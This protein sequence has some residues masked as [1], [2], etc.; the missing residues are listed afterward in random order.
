M[1]SGGSLQL[2][3]AVV[4]AIDAFFGPR[5]SDVDAGRA[6]VRDGIVEL[7]RLGAFEADLAD[8]VAIVARVARHD[9]AS[10]F[11]AWAHR[12]VVEYLEAAAEGVAAGE[13][14]AAGEAW[15]AADPTVVG[16]WLDELRT[17]RRLGAT[18]MAA[19]TA[20]VLAG[21]PLPVSATRVDGH[22]ELRG[23]VPWASN[24]LPPFLVV[25]AVARGDGAAGAIV[26]ALPSEVANVRVDP[27]P[28]LLALNATGS[29]SLRLDGVPVTEERVLAADLGPFVGRILAPFLLVQSAF[30]LGLAERALE[31][32]ETALGPLGAPL[33]PDLDGTRRD[34]DELTR[35][36]AALARRAS[37]ESTAIPRRELLEHRLEAARVAGEAVRL[38]LAAVGGR[39]YVRGHPTERR[40]REAAF[41]PIQSPTEVLLRWLLSRDS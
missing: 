32:A 15:A 17:G 28:D 11:S 14:I 22:L 5:A 24:L 25:T 34:H 16:R 30:C 20:H 18:A 27:Y 1:A 38:E 39:A 4:R 19:G 31:E 35:Q 10:A 37:I 12:S 36:L 41:L 13:G 40:L 23:R 9:L 3:D 2:P 21:T 6:S 7:A 26:V 8:A 29:S 33:R